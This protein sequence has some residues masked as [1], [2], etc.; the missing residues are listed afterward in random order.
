VKPR[1]IFRVGGVDIRLD[2][3]WLVI[4]AL[5]TFLFWDTFNQRRGAAAAVV[6]AVAATLLFFGS[7]L[8]HEV[9]HALEARHRGIEVRSITLYLFG[10]AT[11]TAS[12][13]RRPGDEF[14]VT[15]VGPWTSLVLGCGFGLIAFG[16]GRANLAAVGQVAALLAWSNL[17]LGFFNLLPGAPLDGGRILDSIVW[18]VTGD[19]DRARRV[20]TSAGRLLGYALVLLGFLEALVVSGGFISGLWLAFIGWFLAQA[21]AA[22]ARAPRSA[23]P[24]TEPVGE[25]AR[26]SGAESSVEGGVEEGVEGGA[27]DS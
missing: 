26:D 13:A 25:A 8:G 9:A 4:A 3:S 14:A 17:L 6:M 23:P 27:P 24:R 15:A 7:V 12:E 20:A 5:V 11:E 21:A 22:E 2:N 10:G 1:T 19:H 16:A 18:R